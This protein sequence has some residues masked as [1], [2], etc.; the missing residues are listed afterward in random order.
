MPDR[1]RGDCQLRLSQL[2]HFDWPVEC[3]RSHQKFVKKDVNK[4]SRTNQTLC[5]SGKGSI[6]STVSKPYVV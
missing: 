2:S 6:H 1:Q 4:L 5:P 3:S